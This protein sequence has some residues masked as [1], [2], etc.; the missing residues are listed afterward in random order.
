MAVEGRAN[1][2][3]LHETAHVLGEADEYGGLDDSQGAY[4]VN[5]NFSN[6]FDS[7]EACQQDELG[8]DRECRRVGE[9]RFFT[10]DTI[11][12]DVMADNLKIQML[13]IG[14]AHV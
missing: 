7:L 2:T 10:S 6:I 9:T 1:V 11:P 4:F 14:R 3:L 8:K 13:E 12:E 5:L